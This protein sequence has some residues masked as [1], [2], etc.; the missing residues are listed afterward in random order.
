MQN[1]IKLLRFILNT[2]TKDEVRKIL[3]YIPTSIPIMDLSN[4]DRRDEKFNK[5]YIDKSDEFHKKLNC[6]HCD[7][8]Y[9]TVKGSIKQP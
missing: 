4:I 1:N 2:H 8:P 6:D 7:N 9:I 3:N 5:L